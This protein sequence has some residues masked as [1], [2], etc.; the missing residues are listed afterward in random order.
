MDCPCGTGETYATC[1]GP[2]HRGDRTADTA[3]AL[4]RSRFSAFARGDAAYLLRSWHSTTRPQDL[5][6]DAT[7]EWRR[8][9]VLAATEDE[10]EFV[11]FFHQPG[12]GHDRLHERS[13]FAREGG[14]WRYVGEASR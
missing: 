5:E 2:L 4:M 10:V 11:A 3:E 13:T 14:D 9:R 7:I 12:H 6:L 8:L 1:C